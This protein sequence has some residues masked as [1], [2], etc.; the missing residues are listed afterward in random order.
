MN[1]SNNNLNAL[2]EAAMNAAK[3]DAR[4]VNV[5]HTQHVCEIIARGDMDAISCLA[6][7][8]TRGEI[9]TPHDFGYVVIKHATTE[10]LRLFDSVL[11]ADWILLGAVET[12]DLTMA[13]RKICSGATRLSL[14]LS[15]AAQ[16]GHMD[17]ARMLVEVGAE[18]L[19]CSSKIARQCGH[20][21]LSAW[22]HTPIVDL[23]YDD[24]LLYFD[25]TIYERVSQMMRTM[26]INHLLVPCQKIV[27]P[28]VID[29]IVELSRHFKFY[30]FTFAGK[31]TNVIV[32]FGRVTHCFLKYRFQ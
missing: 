16:L 17:M 15:R 7:G 19:E 18:G 12:N 10:I 4:H 23:Y 26:N 22:L 11:D 14:A 29:R 28:Y 13:W 31:Y 6:D 30:T 25:S 2:A 32:N 21:E 8:M 20:H 3:Y 27:S 5:T 1:C 9:A 24:V